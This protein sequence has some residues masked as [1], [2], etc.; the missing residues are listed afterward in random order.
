MSESSPVA[1][2]DVWHTY[3]KVVGAN[4]MFHR[5]FAAQLSQFLYARFAI[6]PFSFLDL[7]CG[8]AA[9]LAPV[10]KGCQVE[11]YKGVDLSEPALAL[12]VKN[13]GVL[14]CPVEL[15]RNDISAALSVETNVYDVIYSSFALHHLPLEGKAEFFRRAA[16]CVKK[17]GF[18]L[19]VDVMREEEETLEVYCRHYCSWLC[20]SFTALNPQELDFEFHPKLRPR[21]SHHVL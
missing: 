16:R 3:Q 15:V 14:S 12:A 6:E 21:S 5:E 19:L 11:S 20:G 13:L 4:H 7:G 10:L 17:G 1:F 9:T 2:F 8:D 18:L